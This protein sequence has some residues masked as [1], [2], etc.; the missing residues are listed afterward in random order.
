[1]PKR[2]DIDTVKGIFNSKGLVLKEDIYLNNKTKMLYECKKCGYVNKS[3]LYIITNSKG[4]PRCN[5]SIYMYKY[6][7]VVSYLYKE[8]YKLLSTSYTN[9]TQRLRIQCPKGHITTIAFRDWI[10]GCRCSQCYIEDIQQLNISKLNLPLYNTY[11]PQI[12]KYYEVYKIPFG[13]GNDVLL[14]GINCKHCNRIFVP[15]ASTVINRIRSINTLNN[16]ENNF[17]CSDT[18][19]KT[20]SIFGRRVKHKVFK[21]SRQKDWSTLVKDRDRHTC[22]ICGVAGTK[23]VAHHIDPV[24]CNPIESADIDNG[25]TLCTGCDKKV[26]KLPKCSYEYLRNMNKNKEFVNYE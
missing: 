3:T 16:G 6:S 8:N 14:L 7:D 22:Q 2:L 13:E 5:N 18:C 21:P 20:C 25:I 9:S 17:Y 1:M 4:C 12:E 26:H 23:M 19:K 11:A 10:Q 15:N 24:V